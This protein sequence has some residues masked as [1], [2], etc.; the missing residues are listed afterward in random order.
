[1]TAAVAT[2][3]GVRHVA[4]KA[5]LVFSA[6]AACLVGW[7]AV[8]AEPS[9]VDDGWVVQRMEGMAGRLAFWGRESRHA[10]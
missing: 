6:V 10:G 2:H 1:M 8:V 7:P 9:P 4:R 5:W 3:A